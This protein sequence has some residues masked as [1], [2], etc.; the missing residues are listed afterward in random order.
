MYI[1]PLART[2]AE[3]ATSVAVSLA[4][5]V[6]AHSVRV[7]ASDREEAGQPWDGV[8]VLIDGQQWFACCGLEEFMD[9]YEQRRTAALVD[10][11]LQAARLMQQGPQQLVVPASGPVGR[12]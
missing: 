5:A 4:A 3:G 8:R 11:Q 9:L 1:L 2:P 7:T 6:Q 10:Q 12:T